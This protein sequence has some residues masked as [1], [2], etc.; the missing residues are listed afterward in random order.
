MKTDV[1]LRKDQVDTTN[2]NR[3]IKLLKDELQTKQMKIEAK[4]I[5]IRRNQVIEETILLDKF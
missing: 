4:V 1:L 3:D 5:I 2:N